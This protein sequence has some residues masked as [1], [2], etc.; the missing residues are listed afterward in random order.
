MKTTSITVAFVCVSF[1]FFLSFFF[2]FCI[3]TCSARLYDEQMYS[4]SSVCIRFLYA[5]TV[6]RTQIFAHSLQ[7]S[8][9]CFVLFPCFF[10]FLLFLLFLL[11]CCASGGVGAESKPNGCQAE[12]I[13][14]YAI[15]S[16]CQLFPSIFCCCWM[17]AH[18]HAISTNTQTH[19]ETA[20]IH[21][22]RRQ[23]N[24]TNKNKRINII[25][26]K[27]YQCTNDLEFISYE[28]WVS[29]GNN[30]FECVRVCILW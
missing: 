3:S 16:H 12:Y 29:V 6:N 10:F 1:S 25:T 27:L 22:W 30:T 17:Q 21:T 8:N 9:G 5:V 18:Q 19:N 26:I 13:S 7:T 14:R 23:T 11:S 24:G 15:L 2:F 4:F 28:L 20:L